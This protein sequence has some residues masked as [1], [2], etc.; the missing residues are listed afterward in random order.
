MNYMIRY[1]LCY[2]YEMENR[3]ALYTMELA[4]N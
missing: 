3:F 2:F 4:K 1:Q